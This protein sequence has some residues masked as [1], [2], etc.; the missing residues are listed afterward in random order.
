MSRFSEICTPLEI[1]ENTSYES[2]NG[3]ISTCSLALAGVLVINGIEKL[4]ETVKIKLK[5]EQNIHQKNNIYFLIYGISFLNSKNSDFS[6]SIDIAKE[7]HDKCNLNARDMSEL[8]K[9]WTAWE[10][11]KH[12]AVDILIEFRSKC[13]QL[14]GLASPL[15]KYPD[16]SGLVD[17][18]L[19]TE[20]AFEKKFSNL[21]RDI[22]FRYISNTIPKEVDV[23]VLMECVNNLR[24]RVKSLRQ[25]KIPSDLKENRTNLLDSL[26]SI[27]SYLLNNLPETAKRALFRIYH[28]NF[29]KEKSLYPTLFGLQNIDTKVIAILDGNIPISQLGYSKHSA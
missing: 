8:E 24:E 27:S 16:W 2:L 12:I 22:S 6:R 25:F 9:I 13:K 10:E 23:C 5:T 20:D 29:Q 15:E 18:M 19:V 17:K 11:E 4:L 3:G 1:D 28:K 21:H 14:F 7:L 26:S